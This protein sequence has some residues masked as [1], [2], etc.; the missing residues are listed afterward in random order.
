VLYA[1]CE[2]RVALSFTAVASQQHPLR[3]NFRRFLH[4]TKSGAFRATIVRS[5]IEKRALEAG[6]ESSK[7][8]S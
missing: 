7:E 4:A 5:E 6:V 8:A 3:L 1:I 2:L